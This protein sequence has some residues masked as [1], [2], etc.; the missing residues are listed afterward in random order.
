M[1]LAK[2]PETWDRSD[3]ELTTKSKSD[4]GED[5]DKEDYSAF[6]LTLTEDRFPITELE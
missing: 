4:I 3:D 5:S 6:V 2:E 1:N